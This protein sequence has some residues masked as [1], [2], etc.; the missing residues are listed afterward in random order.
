MISI[1]LDK[2][3]S[4]FYICGMN[5]KKTLGT[6]KLRI[7]F[8]NENKKKDLINFAQKQFNQLARRNIEVPIRLYNL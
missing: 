1:G 4:V 6:T 2:S 7:R 3:I 5:A 8:F